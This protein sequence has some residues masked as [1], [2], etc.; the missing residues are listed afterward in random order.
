MKLSEIVESLKL[1]TVVRGKGFG[2]EIT[3]GYV[4]DLLSDVMAN[5]KKG[6]L[7]ITLQIHQNIVAI[8]TLKE[9][10]GIVI[11][12]GK[13]PTEDTIKKAKDEYVTILKSKL[14]AYELSGKLYNLGIHNS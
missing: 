3:G 12:G 1:D 9:L 2:Q 7:W 6:N 4:S 5:S 14:S 13:E 8:A 11:I 10:A